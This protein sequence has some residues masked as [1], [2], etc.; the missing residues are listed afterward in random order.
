MTGQLVPQEACLM[1]HE[2]TN[3]IKKCI[4]YSLLLAAAMLSNTATFSNADISSFPKARERRHL[5]EGISNRKSL[6]VKD[7][8]HG[9]VDPYGEFIA[10]LTTCPPYPRMCNKKFIQDIRVA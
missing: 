2:H 10:F 5:P 3:Y 9:G 7:S 4:F 6:F 1:P 8:S